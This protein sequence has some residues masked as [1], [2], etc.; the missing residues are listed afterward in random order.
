M[1]K[2]PEGRGLDQFLD[3]CVKSGGDSACLLLRD[4]LLRA[5]PVFLFVAVLP[6]SFLIEFVRAEGDLRFDFARV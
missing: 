4:F 1:K 6:A 5:E 3:V 2:A